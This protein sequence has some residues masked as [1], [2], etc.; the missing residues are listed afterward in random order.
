[1]HCGGGD[2]VVDLRPCVPTVR[3]QRGRRR[4]AL[5]WI[6]AGPVA[7]RGCAET[8]AVGVY[9]GPVGKVLQGAAGR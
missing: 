1:M 5:P 6:G 2:E 7:R 4:P 3:V 8:R 9:Q